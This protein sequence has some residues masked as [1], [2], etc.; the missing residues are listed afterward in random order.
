MNKEFDDID[1]KKKKGA[2]HLVGVD[3]EGI[4]PKEGEVRLLGNRH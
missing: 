1:F 4:I 2:K 3:L